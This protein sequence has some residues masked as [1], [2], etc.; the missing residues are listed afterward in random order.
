MFQIGITN[1][2]DNRLAQ[3]SRLGWEIKELR[4]PMDGL[5]AQELERG[6]LK[7]LKKNGADLANK[8]IVGKFDGYS[9]AWSQSTFQVESLRSLI[10]LIDSK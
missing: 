10:S 8:N 1:Y 5:L 7:M 4:G 6:I 9:E 3:H 2:P